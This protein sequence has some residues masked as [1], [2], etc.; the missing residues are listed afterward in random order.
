MNTNDQHFSH[1]RRSFLRCAG[2]AALSLPWL[3]SVA[4]GKGEQAGKP[5]KRMAF[6]YLPNGI[7][8]RGFFPGENDRPLPGFAGQNNVWRFEGQT[9]PPGK[10]PLTLTSTLAPLDK[11]RDKISLITGMDRTFQHGTDSHAQCASCFLTSVAPYEVK[12]SAYPL[13]RTLDH[14]VADSIGQSTPYP[15]LELSCNDHKNNIESIYFDNMSWYGTGHVAPSM[16]N[17]RVVYDRLFGTQSHTSLRNI[18]DLALGNARQMQKRLSAGDRGKF[19]EY[20]DPCHRAKDG[21]HRGD[22]V[23]TGGRGNPASF[24]AFAAK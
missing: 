15:T 18:T 5:A 2:G 12:G 22:E 11:M 16:R 24:R 14:I 3:E 21:S 23:R 1:S 7:T 10:H 8:R 17:P 13:D 4:Q 9:V 20:V 19:E 6:F